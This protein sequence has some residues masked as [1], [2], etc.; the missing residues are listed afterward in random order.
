MAAVSAVGCLAVSVDGEAVGSRPWRTSTSRARANSAALPNR[1]AGDFANA[2]A[3]ACSIASGTVS[4]SSRSGRGDSVNRRA[5]IA[6]SVGA[7]N[8]GAPASIS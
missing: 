5:I 4:R 6:C 3:I 1:S 8:G 2:F 7:E